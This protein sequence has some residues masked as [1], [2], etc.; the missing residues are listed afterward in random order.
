MTRIRCSL[1]DTESISLSL[2][3]SSL[4]L[5]LLCVSFLQAK[6]NNL[7][8][9]SG[10]SKFSST[11]QCTELR[12]LDLIYPD[13][14][15]PD[16]CSLVTKWKKK[17]KEDGLKCPHNNLKVQNCTISLLAQQKE[18][19]VLNTA[20]ELARPTTC[21]YLYCHYHYYQQQL[22]VIIAKN[23]NSYTYYP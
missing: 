14:Q 4:S 19:S 22:L 11:V 5:S 20:P 13:L 1:M 18:N 10:T 3:F 8:H 12:N 16:L 23:D 21:F 15:S 2:S 6:R 7:M 9:G 17:K